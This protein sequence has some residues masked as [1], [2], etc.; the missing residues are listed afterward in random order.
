MAPP[1]PQVQARPQPVKPPKSPT[2]DDFEDIVDHLQSTKWEVEWI[3]GTDYYQGIIELQRAMGSAQVTFLD[4]GVGREVSVVQT[5]T[6]RVDQ[7]GF[8]FLQGS[9]PRYVGT[10]SR[11]VGSQYAPD[12]FRLQINAD[13]SLQIVETCDRNGWCAPVTVR[14]VTV[15]R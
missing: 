14:A 13:G 12:D 4:S 10:G 15:Q 5:L 1:Q 11:S 3:N 8:Y 7:R 2:N 9:N 6:L